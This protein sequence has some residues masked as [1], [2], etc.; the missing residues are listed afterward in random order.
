[1]VFASLIIQL[2]I[3]KKV[4]FLSI[5]LSLFAC[6]TEPTGSTNVKSGES[7]EKVGNDQETS[8]DVKKSTNVKSWLPK[9]CDLLSK[10][11]IS[12]QLDTDLASIKSNEGSPNSQTSSSCF[13]RWDTPEKSNSGVLV[14]LMTNPAPGEL[15]SWAKSFMYTKKVTG[16]NMLGSEEA[17]M[18]EELS[19]GSIDGGLYN[20]DIQK[21]Y[22]RL[23][24]EVVLLVAFNLEI[25]ERKLKSVVKKVGKEVI[26][27][28]RKKMASSNQ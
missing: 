16:E 1:M 27:N 4:F 11:S 6:K 12:D 23:D 21:A 18:F 13:F 7:T 22:W 26:E 17:A 10:K 28:Y 5:V 15:E 20:Y 2:I 25:E 3:M 8:E 9:A 24:E 19:G 14:Q